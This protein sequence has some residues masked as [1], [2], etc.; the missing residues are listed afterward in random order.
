[1][2][3][4]Y[5]REST[6]EIERYCKLNSNRAQYLSVSTHDQTLQEGET[7]EENGPRPVTSSFL[8][9]PEIWTWLAVTAHMSMSCYVVLNWPVSTSMPTL[10]SLRFMHITSYVCTVFKLWVRC[11][12][13]CVNLCVCVYAWES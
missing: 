5:T 9:F 12:C 7:E 4:D 8:L 11:I 6:E 13:V 10:S 3:Q 1:M 2:A